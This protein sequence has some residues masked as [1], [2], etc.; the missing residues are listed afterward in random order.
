MY[1][2]ILISWQSP[3]VVGNGMSVSPLCQG[4]VTLLP[5]PVSTAATL[6]TFE[7]MIPPSDHATHQH[8][9][10]PPFPVPHQPARPLPPPHPDPSPPHSS[11][12]LPPSRSDPAHS[13]SS[14]QSCLV[15]TCSCDSSFLARSATMYKLPE[16]VVGGGKTHWRLVVPQHL[17]SR[18]RD[19]RNVD[20]TTRSEIVEDTG[21]DGS[22]YKGDGFFPLF[23]CQLV[24]L[25]TVSSRQADI[26]KIT[27]NREMLLVAA[28]KD[29]H[30]S[31]TSTSQGDIGQLVC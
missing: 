25:E 16:S 6:Y 28:L 21:S 7:C 31:Q 20:I 30:C 2:I 17:R 27:A 15:G 8:P 9:S 3:G 11:A 4:H 26:E 14:K 5:P 18:L 24:D 10:P 13:P 23:K 12:A 29:R 22:G 1:G 19:H